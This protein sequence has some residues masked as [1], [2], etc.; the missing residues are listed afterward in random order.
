MNTLIHGFNVQEPEES[1]GKL[2]P[3]LDDSFMFNYGW[4]IF[5]ILWHNKIDAKVLKESFELNQNNVIFAHSNGCAI[6]VEAARQGLN[7]K[8]L[9]CINPALKCKTKF[10]D[11][12]ERIIVIH[13]R[14]DKPTRAARFFDKVPL[15]QILIPNSWGAMGAKGYIGNDKRVRNW[16]L[17]EYVK[18]HSDFFDDVNLKRLMPQLN[19][20]IASGVMY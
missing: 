14:H 3:Y 15:I 4:R 11:S 13:T 6:A 16:N 17:S 2:Q 1:T 5:S 10:P 8:T 18:T 20:W 19:D 7:I 9:I 12:I